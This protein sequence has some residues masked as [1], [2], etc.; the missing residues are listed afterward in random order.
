MN[1]FTAKKLGEVL[2]FAEVGA[3]TWGTG[4]AALVSVFGEEK[5]GGYISTL[6]TVSDTI[7]ALADRAQVLATVI[8]KLEKTGDKLRKMRDLYVG[9]E[10]DNPTELL[11]WSGFFEGAAVVHASLLHGAAQEMGHAELAS[12]ATQSLNHHK[13]IFDEVTEQLY[14]VGRTK[15]R[16]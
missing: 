3:E 12:I 10:W 8:T 11:E 14:L 4:R 1:E 7:K 13:S 9:D 15:A 16:G 5:V 2:A 6:N